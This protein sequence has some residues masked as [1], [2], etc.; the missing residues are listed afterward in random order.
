MENNKLEQFSVNRQ[1]KRKLK[2]FLLTA[3]YNLPRIW[4]QHL[5]CVIRASSVNL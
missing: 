3:S 5:N 4:K 1:F 2:T